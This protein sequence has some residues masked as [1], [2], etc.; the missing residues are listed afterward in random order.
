MKFFR[1]LF[2]PENVFYYSDNKLLNFMVDLGSHGSI[3]N[4]ILIYNTVFQRF[5]QINF[6]F[7]LNNNHL[8]NFITEH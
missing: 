3:M 6:S 5:I 7:P 1:V 4:R 8:T 2:I